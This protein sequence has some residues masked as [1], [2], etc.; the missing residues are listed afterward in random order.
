MGTG[1]FLCALSCVCEIWNI[2][3]TLLSCFLSEVYYFMD[4]FSVIILYVL[5]YIIL[6]IICVSHNIVCVTVLTRQGPS[7]R[8]VWTIWCPSWCASNLPMWDALS[9]MVQREQVT[10][11]YLFIRL[12]VSSASVQKKK[13]NRSNDK[14]L[15]FFF[16]L[17]EL[18]SY[19]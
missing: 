12:P 2:F 15:L 4:L 6:Y 17:T 5:L 7:S 16:I 19:A 11:I 13:K 1:V 3:S 14:L 9:P 18:L 8:Q 10:H